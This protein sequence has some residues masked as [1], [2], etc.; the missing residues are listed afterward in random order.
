MIAETLT[1]HQIP[2]QYEYPLWLDAFGYVRPDFRCL[3]IR[4][5]QIVFWEHQGRM[6]DPDYATH[7]I[8][9]IRAYEE[10]GIYVG[11]NLIIT[12]ESS[13]CPLNPDTVERW[14]ERLLK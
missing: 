5:R 13:D 3:N 4:K 1:R 11:Q 14:I 9:K 10:S 7:A 8:R 2:Y 6:D 12:R